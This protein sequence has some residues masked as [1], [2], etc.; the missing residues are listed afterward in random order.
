[1]PYRMMLLHHDTTATA[2]ALLF[3]IFKTRPS[4]FCVLD[5][6]DAPLDEENDR[7]FIRGIADFSKETQFIVITH[8]KVTMSH[9]DAIY[10]VTMQEPG[11]TKKISVSFE[12]VEKALSAA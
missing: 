11:V 10:G 8:K 2:I 5:E 12:Q 7:R 4:P 9:A 1:M 6:A 3:A